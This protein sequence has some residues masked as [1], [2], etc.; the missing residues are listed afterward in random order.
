[1]GSEHL[2]SC[3]ET[4]VKKEIQISEARQAQGH[5]SVSLALRRLKQED[6]EF[7][8]NLDYAARPDLK[9]RKKKGG[10]EGHQLHTAGRRSLPV[11]TH[12]EPAQS[13]LFPPRV[14]LAGTQS[15]KFV[16]LI[17]GRTRMKEKQCNI[18]AAGKL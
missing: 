12:G 13:G 4:P 15:Y 11:T 10:R 9:K 18:Q 14:P 2:K 1:M 3:L 16:P 6:P 17:W 5:T 8:A 7:E